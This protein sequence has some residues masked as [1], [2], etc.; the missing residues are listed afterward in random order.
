MGDGASRAAARLAATRGT[1]CHG[2]R[3]LVDA[4]VS[5]IFSSFA[6]FKAGNG[7]FRYNEKVTTRL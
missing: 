1:G 5:R 3:M 6:P 7:G 4:G 2:R